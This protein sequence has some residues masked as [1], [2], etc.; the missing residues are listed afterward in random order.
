[1]KRMIILCFL[2]VLF[3]AV[4]Q[5]KVVTVR[6]IQKGRAY[7]TLFYGARLEPAA[8]ISYSSPV[9]GIVSNIMVREG[10]VV[11]VGTPLISVVRRSTASDFLPSVV[12]S[13]VNGVVARINVN[14][15]QE[16][17]E[18]AEMIVI[19]DVSSYKADLLLS[20]KDIVRIKKGDEVYI[21]NTS[22]K[23]EISSLS[24]IPEGNTGLFRSTVH[25]KPQKGLFSGMFL[26][27][28][29]RVEYFEGI[30][31]PVE[32]IVNRYGKTMVNLAADNK[33]VFRE[34]ETGKRYGSRIAVVKGL[35]EGDFVIIRFN[36]TIFDGDEVVVNVESSERRT[37]QDSGEPSGGTGP[38]L[39][40]GRQ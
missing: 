5:E 32:W 29:I 31:I 35:K 14:A 10:D 16:I 33:V 25:F 38:G 36:R 8:L 17:S 15:N 37:G 11:R 9:T 12:I 34:V 26:E 21:R 24:I 3:Q 13:Q 20:D 30:L 18:R 19:A 40:R 28:E 2:L 39:G 7:D 27:L 4:S 6:K 23:G 22:I 1:M